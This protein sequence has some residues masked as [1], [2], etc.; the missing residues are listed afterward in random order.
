MFVLFRGKL[1]TTCSEPLHPWFDGWEISNI[2]LSFKK[3]PTHRI[4]SE[5]VFFLKLTSNALGCR[6][7]S[8]PLWPLRRAICII[9]LKYVLASWPKACF[10]LYLLLLLFTCLLDFQ[11]L[12]NLQP[13]YQ[14]LKKEIA[15]YIIFHFCYITV[16]YT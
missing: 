2:Y 5:N 15:V 12:Q 10:L 9:F 11:M 8:R 3:G 16:E 4:C 13:W 1:N 7:G 14:P 6:E